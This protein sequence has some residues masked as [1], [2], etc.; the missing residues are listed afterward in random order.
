[1]AVVVRRVLDLSHHNLVTNLTS[2]KNAGIWGII[3]K[4][5][6]ATNYKDPKY[7][8]R[9]K[10]FLELGVLWGAYHFLHP[11]KI[12]SIDNQLNWFLGYAGVDQTTLYALDWEAASTGTPTEDD[13]VAFMQGLA[14]ATGREG[15][16]YS[17]NVAKE[18]ISGVN[19]YLGSLRLWLA[20]YAE[21]GIKTQASW[22][23]QVWLWQYSDGEAGPAPHGCPGVT[24][25]VDTNSWT[26]TQAALSAQWSGTG[27]APPPA[28]PVV[29][30]T[31]DAPA[32]VNVV[33]NVVQPPEEPPPDQPPA[34]SPVMSNIQATIFDVGSGGAYGAISNPL[35]VS[36][37]WRMS[38]TRKDKKVTNR[39][40]GKSAVAVVGDVGPWMIDDNYQAT[41]ARPIAETCFKN[42]TALP[43]GPNAGK[44][45]TN[46]AGI[47]LSPAL[48]IAIGLP[49]GA[50]GQGP[51]DWEDA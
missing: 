35:Y 36:L 49:G 42:K 18:Q 12:A 33:V 17:G 44:I 45:P 8:A 11:S 9:K 22:K 23:N 26:D 28:L 48:A 39:A 31:I 40:N 14:K 38:G 46:P 13:A 7:P 2:V 6:E 19:A 29:N 1:M 10:G 34:T 37:P 50:N 15:V 5:T 21:T 51:V 3:H 20:Q 32:G 47:D 41:G 25:L 24:G 4:A 43:S 16:V 27:V 30:I